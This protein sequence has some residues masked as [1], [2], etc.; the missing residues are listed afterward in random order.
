MTIVIILTIYIQRVILRASSVVFHCTTEGPTV[1]FNVRA[2]DGE[3]VVVS[4]SELSSATTLWL[5]W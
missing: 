2:G 1:V 5:C 4:G 3:E